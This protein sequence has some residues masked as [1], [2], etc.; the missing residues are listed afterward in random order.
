MVAVT[1]ENEKMASA[2]R[3]EAN[4]LELE[5]IIRRNQDCPGS[6]VPVVKR[7]DHA[8]MLTFGEQKFAVIKIW[9]A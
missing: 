2:T 1:C 4:C 5:G 6:I 7:D 9:S 8:F 3:F